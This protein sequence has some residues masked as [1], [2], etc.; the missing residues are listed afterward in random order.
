LPVQAFAL[1]ELTT[2]ADIL[3]V[4]KC[5]LLVSTAADTTL[6]VVKTAAAFAPAGQTIKPKSF[7]LDFLMPQAIPAARNPLGDVIVLFFI[8]FEYKLQFQL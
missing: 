3:A 7:F 1:P 4:V 5:F 8:A 2:T 6:L